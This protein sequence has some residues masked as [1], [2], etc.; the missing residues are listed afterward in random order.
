VRTTEEWMAGRAGALIN[1]GL[2]LKAIQP[3]AA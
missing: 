1:R 2:S 3:S